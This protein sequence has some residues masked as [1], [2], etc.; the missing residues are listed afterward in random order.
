MEDERASTSEWT[1]ERVGGTEG[2]MDPKKE[3]VVSEEEEAQ[4]TSERDTNGCV[5]ARAERSLRSP[6]SSEHYSKQLNCYPC[7]TGSCR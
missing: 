6:S 5:G 7:V 3:R 4:R 2:Q 1:D